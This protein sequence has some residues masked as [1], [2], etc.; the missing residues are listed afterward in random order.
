MLLDFFLLKI[1]G[2]I[3]VGDASSAERRAA[4]EVRNLLD[5]RR[6]HDPR[7][8]NGDI[9]KELV[10]IDVLLSVRVDKIVIMV[11]GNRQDRLAIELG[12]VEAVQQVNAAG[13]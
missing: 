4:R 3:D 5:V 11:T 1:D 6:T 7:V 2:K 13:A 12:I 10:E 8:V 9:H